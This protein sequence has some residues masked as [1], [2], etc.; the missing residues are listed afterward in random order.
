MNIKDLEIGN[1]YWIQRNNAAYQVNAK[2]L[3]LNPPFYWGGRLTFK[4]ENE[5]IMGDNQMLK[6]SVIIHQSIPIG[7]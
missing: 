3:V 1:H 4:A 6:P 5:L 7:L 2:F